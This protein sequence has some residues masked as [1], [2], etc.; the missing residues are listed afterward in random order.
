VS[1]SVSVLGVPTSAGSH[2]PGQEKAPAAWRAAG[3]VDGLRGAGLDVEDRGDLP[4]APFRPVEPVDGLRDLDRVVAVAEGVAAEVAAIRAAGRL[5]LVLGGDCTITLGAL[6]G[7]GDGGLVY[8]DGDA[9]LSTPQRSDSAVADTMGMTHMLGGGSPRLA[10]LGSRFPLLRPEQVVLFGFDPAELDTGEWTELVSRHLYAAPAPTVRA[11]PAG[12]AREARAYLEDRTDAYLVHLDV[13]VLHTGLFPLGNFPHFAGLT[14]DQVTVCL[15]EFTRGEKFGGLV[16]TE[17]NP[18]HDRDGRHIGTLARAVTSALRPALSSRHARYYRHRAARRRVRRRL[19]S[20]GPATPAVRRPEQVPASP[21]APGV[22][23]S[24]LLDDQHGCRRLHQRLLRFAGEA[25]V[26]GTAQGH[27][28]AWYVVRGSG[29]LQVEASGT[30]VLRPGTAVWMRDSLRYRCRARPGLEIL[31]VV[32]RAAAPADDGRPELCV[33]SL[34]E[35]E[36][37][38]TGNREF[39]V[40]LSAGLAITQFAGLIPPG[41]APEHHHAYDEV[42]HVLAGHGVVHLSGGSTEIGPGTSIYLPPQAPHCLENRGPD[43]LQV[44]GVF[45]PAGSPAAKQATQGS[46]LTISVER[47]D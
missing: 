43:P 21:L 11:D 26:T 39:R 20:T 38:R 4:A 16:I 3:L 40:L 1:Q 2:N 24:E 14:L 28:E 32:V 27:G 33:A 42:V 8:F 18:D 41:R 12:R 10:G 47:P 22:T 44:L 6:A 29:V 35:C 15:N 36:P 17:V 25:E 19:M 37:E 9:D 30:A 13:D 5:P 31:A 45:C 7:F 23:V 34:E 46:G